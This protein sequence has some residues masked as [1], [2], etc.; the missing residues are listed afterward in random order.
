MTPIRPDTAKRLGLRKPQDGFAESL[1]A[2][3]RD[4]AAVMRMWYLLPPV[5]LAG[6]AESPEEARERRLR[7]LGYYG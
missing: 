1:A 2:A 7:Q 3:E 6:H 4:I 5:I